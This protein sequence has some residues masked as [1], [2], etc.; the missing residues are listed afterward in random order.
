V[1]VPPFRRSIRLL[2]SPSEDEG[3]LLASITGLKAEGS[4]GASGA[5]PAV[6]FLGAL[7]TC[8]L[9][10]KHR[11]NRAGGQ[12]VIVFVGSPVDTD[13]P[14]LK[15]LGEQLRKSNVRALAGCGGEQS[16]SP[17]PSLSSH[18]PSPAPPLLLAPTRRSASTSSSW[19]RTT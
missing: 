10:L 2:S 7:K 15:K 9:A 3:K 4:G 19:A 11:K 17:S 8:M 6:G 13:A 5:G 1:P 12:R 16:S 18:P 14:V